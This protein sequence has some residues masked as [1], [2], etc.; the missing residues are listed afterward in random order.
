MDERADRGAQGGRMSIDDDVDAF[1]SSL[2]PAQLEAFAHVDA[3]DRF[4]SC[5]FAMA[6]GR[7]AALGANVTDL[8]VVTRV[9]ARASAR[10]S[11]KEE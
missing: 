4:V 3:A 9:V 1:R 5:L 2:T 10:A 8:V 6:A 7:L 11:S